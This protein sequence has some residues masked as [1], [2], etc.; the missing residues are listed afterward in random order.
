MFFF[1]LVPMG[2]RVPGLPYSARL[3][4]R[5]QAASYCGISVTTFSALC[6]VQPIALGKDKRLERF[7]VVALDNWIDRIST[8]GASC[9][10]DWL[11]AMDAD[12]DHGSG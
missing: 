1:G 7:D 10:R 9:G 8:A 2:R 4:T 6:P 12:H 3:L 11:A 5:A